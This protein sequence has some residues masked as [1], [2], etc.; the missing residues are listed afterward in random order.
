MYQKYRYSNG[1]LA[2][3]VAKSVSITGV[4]RLLNIRLT[5]GSHSHI[6]KRIKRLNLDTA[7][8]LGQSANS[9]QAHR[10]G[11]KTR[12]EDLLVK[13]ADGRRT[14]AHRLR[15]A[16]LETGRGHQCG[17][18]GLIP[19]WNGRRLVLQVDHINRDFLDDRPDNL[20][21]LCPNCHSQTDGWCGSKGLTGV[22]GNR[23][24]ETRLESVIVQ[25]DAAKRF[26]EDCGKII[27]R[28]ATRCKKCA[29]RALPTQIAWPA[30]NSLRQMVLDSNVLQ[31]SIKLGVAYNSV[32]KRLRRIDA[33]SRLK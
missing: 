15:R 8:F 10:G 33:V 30:D 3:A 19:E 31:V 16:L 4:L 7:H 26:C 21:F 29:R 32:K 24:A 23:T 18:C 28:K 1:V 13:R 14:I 27:N 9:G 22:K 20:R 12:P 17:A 11:R 5:G 6:S 2:D 25:T